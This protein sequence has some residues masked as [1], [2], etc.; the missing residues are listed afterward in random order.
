MILCP[1]PKLLQLPNA[2]HAHT[3]EGASGFNRLQLGVANP[4]ESAVGVEVGVSEPSGSGSVAGQ[5]SEVTAVGRQMDMVVSF[6]EPMVC[7]TNK[8]QVLVTW[9]VG[10]G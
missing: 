6:L 8:N 10:T 5:A 2:T 1:T 9:L 4:N 7:V 3:G